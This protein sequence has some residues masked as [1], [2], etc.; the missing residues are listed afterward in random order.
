MKLHEIADQAIRDNN[1]RLA[2]GLM[3]RLCVRHGLNYAGVRE[4]LQAHG[5]NA[6]LFFEIVEDGP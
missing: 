5:V 6:D 2:M 3:K 4:Y 1:Y